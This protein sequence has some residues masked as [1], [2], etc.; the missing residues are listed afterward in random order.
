MAPGAIDLLATPRRGRFAR[1]YRRP[2][3]PGRAEATRR[4]QGN[5]AFVEAAPTSWLARNMALWS[6]VLQPIRPFD[7]PRARVT[8]WEASWPLSRELTSARRARRLVTAQ[9]DEWDL[10]ELAETAELLVSELVTNALRHTRGPLRLNLCLRGDRLVCEVED[11]EPVCPVR[12]EADADA[13]GGRGTELLDLLAESWGSTCTPTGKT[14][15][16][17]VPTETP[18]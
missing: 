8:P 9:L 13:E 18:S 12:R 10:E 7:A 16:F 3:G 17:E 5:E 14:M 1:L 6:R 11:T 2:E 4:D 15:W